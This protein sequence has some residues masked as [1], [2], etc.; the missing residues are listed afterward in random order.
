MPDVERVLRPGGVG[1]QITDSAR[2]EEYVAGAVGD[3]DDGEV[4]GRIS[5]V[6]EI[7]DPVFLAGELGRV[8]DVTK[9][10]PS[11]QITIQTIPARASTVQVD[12]QALWIALVYEEGVARVVRAAGAGTAGHP[13]PGASRI[14][15]LSCSDCH[16]CRDDEEHHSTSKRKHPEPTVQRE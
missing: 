8:D 13:I 1:T 7:E 9:R 2:A 11:V 3:E 16:G 10:P 12:H 15:G 5:R 4:A 6:G 14:G